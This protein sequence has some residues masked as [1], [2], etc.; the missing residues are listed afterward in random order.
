MTL[1]NFKYE[2]N[3]LTFDAINN[4][5]DIDLSN[6]KYY[7]ETYNSNKTLLE[8]Y[9]IDISNILT[10][11][12]NSFEYEI[13]NNFEYFVIA[14]KSVDDYPSVTLIESNGVGIL[15]C[16]KDIETIIY[17]FKDNELTSIKHSIVD[18]NVNDTNYYSKLTLYQN[19]VNIYNN[20]SGINATFNSTENGFS[21]IFAIE[22]DKAN[23]FGLSEKY[24]YAY[25]EKAKVVKF[26]MQTYGF[27]CS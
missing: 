11:T 20:I 12:K 23:L 1:N 16:Y 9:K 22:L 14:E 25:K 18:N 17:S 24:Y 3:K 8:R 21:S 5:K 15:T 7:L 13:K 19:K 10:N 6:K 4:N 27:S 26:E 2:N